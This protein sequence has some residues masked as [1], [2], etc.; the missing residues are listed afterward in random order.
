MLI[1]NTIIERDAWY[2]EWKLHGKQN[3]FYAQQFGLARNKVVDMIRKR[4]N[5]ILY[6]CS[7]RKAML[8]K[9]GKSLITL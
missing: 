9:C 7:K 1:L 3:D 6:R 5:F 8:K 4:K 2:C